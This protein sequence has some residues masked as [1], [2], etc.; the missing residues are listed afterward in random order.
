MIPS[1]DVTVLLPVRDAAATI[2]AALDSIR[3]QTHR[4]LEIL[5]VDDGSVD[6]TP[7]R[8]AAHAAADNRVQIL[9]LERASGIVLALNAG[10][11]RARAPWLARMDADDV[12]HPERL[13]RQRADL[14]A[15]PDV[16]I[17]DTRVEIVRDDGPAAG[18]FQAYCGWLDTIETH[19][20]F[21]REFL[22]ENPV[23]HPA[24]MVRTSL[25]HELGGY[26]D[27]PFPEDYDL[28][29]RCLRA[30]ARFRKLPRRL[31]RW[32]DGDHRLT[33]TDPRYARRAF[34]D[35]KWE[36]LAQTRLP[37]AARVAV[38]GAGPGARPWR[39][40]LA[41]SASELVA[42][43]DIDPAKI[44]RTRHGVLVRPV[45]EVQ[46]VDFDLLVVAVGAR[47]ARAEIRERLAGT[48]LQEVED[49]VFVS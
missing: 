11:D 29:L 15:H 18:G 1:P 31:L 20:D 5:V 13:A 44:G 45:E 6:D 28:W 25:L 43:F 12:S 16:D 17:C 23:V 22:V 4:Y 27:G 34:F 26:R 48:A 3:E 24:A 14:E 49:F 46:A 9:R 47:G 21:V 30:G 2:D 8:L 41:Q 42:V 33:R 40:A 10:L 38:W 36:H 32:T 35:L 39:R 19:D 37:A 7:A